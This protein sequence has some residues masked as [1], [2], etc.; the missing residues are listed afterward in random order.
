LPAALIWG[1]SGGIGRALVIEL[2]QAGWQVFAAARNESAV[3]AEADAVC[4][5]D[6]ANPFTIEQA[7]VTIAHQIW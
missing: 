4:Y 1:A 2:K 3:P 6:A 5:F 7:A